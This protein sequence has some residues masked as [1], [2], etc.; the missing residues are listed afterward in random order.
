MSE[1]T[2]SSTPNEN[3]QTPPP[4]KLTPRSF[5]LEFNDAFYQGTITVSDLG[6]DIYCFYDGKE[7]DTVAKLPFEN[8]GI[9]KQFVDKVNSFVNNPKTR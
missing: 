8:E 2:Q 9:R 7:Y 4:S 5:G 1:E 3:P 6:V